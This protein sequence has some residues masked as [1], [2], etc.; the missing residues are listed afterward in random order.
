MSLRGEQ[1]R[2]HPSPETML[3]ISQ[4]GFNKRGICMNIISERRQNTGSER[5]QEPAGS[6]P[7]GESSRRKQ[8]GEARDLSFGDLWCLLKHARSTAHTPAVG[9]R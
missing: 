5:R 4:H 6:A 8:P 9:T 3:V 7:V 1:A 2:K